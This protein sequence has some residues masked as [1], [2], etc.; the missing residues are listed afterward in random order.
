MDSTTKEGDSRT[1]AV[2]AG[3][4]TGCRLGNPKKNAFMVCSF[5]FVVG[6]CMTKF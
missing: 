2:V 1:A 6:H 5:D 4:K 3:Y